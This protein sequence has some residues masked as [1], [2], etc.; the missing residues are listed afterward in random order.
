MVPPPVLHTAN[1][2]IPQPSRYMHGTGIRFLGHEEEAEV[3]SRTV[4]KIA[5]S[6]PSQP[7][8][9]GLPMVPAFCGSLR[10][11]IRLP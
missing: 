3:V 1:N 11:L 4:G 5:S 2:N 10:I 9:Y 6:H 8:S 7:Y